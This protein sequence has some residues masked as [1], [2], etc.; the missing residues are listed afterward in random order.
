[1]DTIVQKHVLAE[2]DVTLAKAAS[3]AQSVEVAE[4]A[5]KALQT[6]TGNM[7]DFTKLTMELMQVH[8][9]NKSGKVKDKYSP[10]VIAMVIST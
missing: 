10:V 2:T 5:V 3:L 1:M 4:K 8:S 6:S 7:T 9:E